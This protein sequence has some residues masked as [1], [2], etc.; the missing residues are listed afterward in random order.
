M[1]NAGRRSTDP[2]QSPVCA[3]VP[4]SPLGEAKNYAA[5]LPICAQR[6][7]FPLGE[8]GRR[9]DEGRGQVG[10]CAK[11]ERSTDPHQSPVCALVPASPLGE[12]KNYAATLPICARTPCL[13]P[14]GKVAEGRMRVG[15]KSEFAQRRKKKYRPSS[16]TSVRTGASFPQGEAKTGDADSLWHQL[17]DRQEK[18]R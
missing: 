7:C 1:R 18:A 17:S 15:G 6:P 4:A 9:P 16:V 13:P 3:L 8:G 14:W 11:P 2:H 5:T 10:V 12:A